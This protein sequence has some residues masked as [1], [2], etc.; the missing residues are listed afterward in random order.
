MRQFFKRAEDAGRASEPILESGNKYSVST[1][2]HSINGELILR[3]I[4]QSPQY[5]VLS[6]QDRAR[7]EDI[8]A[9]VFMNAELRNRNPLHPAV[10]DSC[11]I[12]NLLNFPKHIFCFP[13]A[14]YGTDGYESLSLCMYAPGRTWHAAR[15][16][17]GACTAGAT[18]AT[19]TGLSR[20]P[21]G[22][23]AGANTGTAI[24]SSAPPQ[25]RSC[26]ISAPRVRF[27]PARPCPS[28]GLST[29]RGLGLFGFSFCCLGTRLSDTRHTTYNTTSAY[30]LQPRD[31]N[32]VIAQAYLRAQQR[33]RAR[34][35]S[36]RQGSVFLPLFF[37][38]SSF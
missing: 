12:G 7:L 21:H 23:R 19:Q 27:P 16:C 26:S 2:F 11:V 22:A 29:R 5:S 10:V 6:A 34:R 28:F 17:A 32:P 36:S 13:F 3:Q 35:S 30:D 18:H 4:R 31:N 38:Y 25:D 20:A 8:S 15:L 1:A 9:A 24:V 33:P 37:A 14:S